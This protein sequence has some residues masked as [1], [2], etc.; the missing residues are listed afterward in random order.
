MHKNQPLKFYT[1]LEER[2]NVISHAIGFFLSLGAFVFL[3][4][5]SLDSLW[6]LI[7]E[8][9]APAADKKSNVRNVQLLS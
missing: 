3:I 8:R 7:K 6:R 4:D 1:P 9:K 5:K 2:I